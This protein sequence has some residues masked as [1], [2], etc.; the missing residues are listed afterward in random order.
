MNEPVN[1]ALFQSIRD[2]CTTTGMSMS[3][4]RRG[5]RAGSIPF[6]RAGEKYMVNVTLLLRKL[7][8]E[9]RGNLS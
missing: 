2:A 4:L 6:V 5:I 7:D 8:E 1:Q 9:S 3:Y